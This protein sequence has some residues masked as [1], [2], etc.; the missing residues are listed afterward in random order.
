MFFYILLN[1][2]VHVN[3]IYIVESNHIDG[4]STPSKGNVNILTGN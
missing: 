1:Q 4:S 2:E 3:E